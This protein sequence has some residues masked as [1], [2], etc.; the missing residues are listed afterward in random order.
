MQIGD[1]IWMMDNLAY[2]LP[3]GTAG[4]CLTWNEASDDFTKED[5]IVDE[6]NVPLEVTDEEYTKLYVDLLSDSSYDWDTKLGGTTVKNQVLMFVYSMLPRYGQEG[7]NNAMAPY[8]PVFFDVFLPMLEEYKLERKDTYIANLKAEKAAIPVKHTAEAEALNGGY[9]RHYGYLYTLEGAR[10]AIPEG[11]RLPSDEDWKKLEM[12]IGM[13]SA[14]L[15]KMNAWRGPHC[16]DFLKEGG[17]A[18]FE[19][20]MAGCNAYVSGNT[21]EY[22]KKGDCA[23][24]WTSEEKE[25]VNNSENSAEEGVGNHGIV[26]EGVIRSIAIYSSQ[27]WRGTTRLTNTYRGTTYSVRCVKDIR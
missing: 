12:S 7:F 4:G 8:Y 26:K 9:S 20:K 21:E 24:F 17:K 16:G 27:I 1:Q 22:I 6:E 10:N 14:D 11:W 5:L 25:I 19:G 23:Y 3:E 2:Y 15:E 13:L 18:M